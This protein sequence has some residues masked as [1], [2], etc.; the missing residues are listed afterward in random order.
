M[1]ILRLKIDDDQ[2]CLVDFDIQL[3]IADGGSSTV[4]IGENGTG[5]SSMLEAIC[6]ILLS[7]D[8]NA[9]GK[10]IPFNYYFEYVYAAKKV[11]IQCQ[12]KQ[13]GINVVE[14]G[15]TLHFEGA[16]RTIR[17]KLNEANCSIFPKRIIAYY[18]GANDKLFPLFKSANQQYL[19]KCSDE[20]RQYLASLKNPANDFRSDFPRRKYN[21]CNE[22]MTSIFLCA[23]LG[24]LDLYEKSYLR[25]NCRF[26]HLDDISVEIDMKKVMSFYTHDEFE[27]RTM[28]NELA[29][30]ISFIDERFLEKFQQGFLYATNSKAIFSVREIETLNLDSISIFDFFEKLSSLFSAKLEAY[31]MLGES[32][33]RASQMSEGQRQLVK[34]LGMLGVCKDEDCLVLMDEPDAHMNPKWKYEIKSVIDKSLEAAIN[35]QAII[36]THDP[37]VINGVNKAFI[38]IFEYN[39]ALFEHNGIYATK[40]C[41]PTEDTEGMGID[42]LLQSE[43]YGLKTSYDKASSDKYIERQELYIKLINGEITEDEKAKLKNLTDELGSLSISFNTIDF[44]YDDFIKVFRNTELY[45]KEYLPYD[46]IIARRDKI[47]EIIIAL[48]EEQV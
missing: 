27:T 36:S 21:Y 24:G 25:E 23:I 48:Y 40:I 6:K 32:R 20:I 1:Q 30:I 42:G 17:K 18:S 38:R 47:K 26:A 29:S 13:Y 12:N 11:T 44:L 41:V 4:L 33:V 8:F 45:S 37:L 3:S 15:T 43:Y 39:Q 28:A 10:D 7:F 35:T 2:K 5:K 9:V 46:D 31:V 19:R 22:E 16:M 14:N 34:M